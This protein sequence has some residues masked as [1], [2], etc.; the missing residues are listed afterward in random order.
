[1]QK[2]ENSNVTL[3]RLGHKL[4]A[5]KYEHKSKTNYYLF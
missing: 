2:W 3:L 5:K 4:S 1:M